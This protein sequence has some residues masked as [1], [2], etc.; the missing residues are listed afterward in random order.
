V[1][2]RTLTLFAS[3]LVVAAIA[4]GTAG[5]ATIC[6]ADVCVMTGG[7]AGLQAD[8]S[9][10]GAPSAVTQLL[11][12]EVALAERLHPPGPCFTGEI[13]PPSPCLGAYRYL[14]SAATLVLVDAQ[15][16]LLG[17]VTA[18]SCP[19]GCSVPT[20]AARLIDGDIRTMLA[21]PSI[22]PTGL[23]SLPALP[24]GSPN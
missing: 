5:A 2:L 18:Y 16:R 13:H 1:R 15:V 6:N 23:I 19:G 10:S 21:D 7:F 14:A 20:A 22:Y 12:G 24:P 17:G 8:I 3:L 4:T 9:T 11:S